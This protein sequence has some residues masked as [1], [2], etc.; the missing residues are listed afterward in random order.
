MDIVP[1]LLKIIPILT[2]GKLWNTDFDKTQSYQGFHMDKVLLINCF[3]FWP[4]YLE[5]FFFDAFIQFIV[6]TI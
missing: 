4:F 5:F 3:Y 1:D 2:T 6:I